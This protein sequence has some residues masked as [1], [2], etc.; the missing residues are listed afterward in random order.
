MFRVK[1]LVVPFPTRRTLQSVVDI[2]VVHTG[3]LGN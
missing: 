3:T 1:D 2:L